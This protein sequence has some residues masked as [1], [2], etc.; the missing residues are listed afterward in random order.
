MTKK[1]SE[2]VAS[3]AIF[4]E[5]GGYF[6]GGRISGV[7]VY[8]AK[9]IDTGFESLLVKVDPK[10]IENKNDWPHS[11]GFRVLVRLNSRSG[12]SE[13]WLLLDLVTAEFRGLFLALA[14]DLCPIL[15]S[16]G[17]QLEAVT[18]L[19]ERLFCWQAFLK[20]RKDLR[21]FNSGLMEVGFLEAHQS[22]YEPVLYQAAERLGFSVVNEFSRLNLEKVLDGV[23]CQ[24]PDQPRC[25]STV[26][27]GR[28]LAVGTRRKFSKPFEE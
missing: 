22:L 25:L 13:V 17:D 2:I 15:A 26:C 16:G 8:A 10:L 6:Q 20:G 11:K 14:E 24:L 18:V 5:G 3:L 9:M 1:F 27:C 28:G 21:N 12:D 19:R 23:K 7:S 4:G